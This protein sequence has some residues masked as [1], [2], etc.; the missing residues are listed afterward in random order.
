MPAASPGSARAFVPTEKNGVIADLFPR[1]GFAPAGEGRWTLSLAAH[2]A[3]AT[4]I[5]RKEA[6]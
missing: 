4:R 3:R 6:A 2:A 1:L 5:R